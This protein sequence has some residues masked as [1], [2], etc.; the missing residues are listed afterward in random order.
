MPEYE[1][2]ESP[3]ETTIFPY[4]D[5]T[6]PTTRDIY[7][8]REVV[9]EYVPRT[10]LVRSENLSA[11]LDADVYLKREDVL[12]TRSFKIRGFY[13]LVADLDEEFR[14]TGLITSSMGNHGQGMATAAREFGV[15]ATIVVPET[16]ENPTKIQNME[17]LGATVR[18][19]GRDVD[20]ARE[21]AEGLAAE[22][23]YRYVHGGNEPH[24][25]AGRASAGLEVMEDCPEVDVLINPVGGGSSAAAYCLTV[26]KLL[27]A[28]VVG[29]QA[30]GADAVYRAW[31]EGVIEVQEEADTFAEGIKTRT[32][33]GLPLEIMREHLADMVLV[34]DDDLRDAIY[35][36]LTADSVLAEGAAATSVA[37]ALSLGD[38]LAGETVVLPISGGNL[39]TA[40][41]KEILDSRA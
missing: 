25:I 32:P 38:E 17:R 39:S 5:V 13:N 37:G 24:L 27:G 12:P 28:D 26:G 8:A 1:P 21:V 41:L 23:G 11:E 19:C 30:T 2:V 10:P 18:K 35:R 34:E 3:D 14:E 16:L 20:E 4:H 7:E 6:P 33:F 29:V 36:L 22:E 15:P 31:S 40:K 9:E